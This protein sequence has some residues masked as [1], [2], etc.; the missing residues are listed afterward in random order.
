M[1]ATPWPRLALGVGGGYPSSYRSRRATPVVASVSVHRGGP[2]HMVGQQTTKP[3]RMDNGMLR[4]TFPALRLDVVD[5]KRPK[6]L[7]FSW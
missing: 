5:C 4:A 6:A 2:R 7:R 3:K 1:G